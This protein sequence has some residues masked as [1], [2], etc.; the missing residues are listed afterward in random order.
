[1]NDGAIWVQ[2]EDADGVA[3]TLPTNEAGNFFTEAPLRAPFR[4]KVIRGDQVRA[5]S[6]LAEHGDC[7]GC[8]TQD[9]AE[10]APGRI[11]AP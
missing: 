1:V 11:M 2:V 3:V 5:M 8:H 9:G 10:D 7:S 6:E 4:V